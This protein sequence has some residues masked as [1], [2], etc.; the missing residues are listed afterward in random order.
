MIDFVVLNS[1]FHFQLI[2]S[3]CERRGIYPFYV[4]HSLRAFLMFLG[5][6]KH[7]NQK[8]DKQDSKQ[9]KDAGVD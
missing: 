4:L 3:Q 6:S 8:Q 7:K 5:R 2:F 1:D 9:D